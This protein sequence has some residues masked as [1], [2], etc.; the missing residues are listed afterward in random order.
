MAKSKCWLCGHQ[1]KGGE[2]FLRMFPGDK[3]AHK[4]C[5]DICGCTLRQ[6]QK[7]RENEAHKKEETAAHGDEETEKEPKTFNLGGSEHEESYHYELGDT[8]EDDPRQEFAESMRRFDEENRKHRYAIW[9]C[10]G[11]LTEIEEDIKRIHKLLEEYIALQQEVN[12]CLDREMKIFTIGMTLAS[13]AIVL[14]T[15]LVMCSY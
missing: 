10:Y 9:Q 2:G 13:G 12:D 6:R 5:K 11:Q 1:L 7:A 3:Q 14:G 4:I 8:P 15:F